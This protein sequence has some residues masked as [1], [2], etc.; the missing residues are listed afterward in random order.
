MN[1][2]SKLDILTEAISVNL[3]TFNILYKNIM[4]VVLE[5]T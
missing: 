1:E 3:R 4:L 2:M 5:L